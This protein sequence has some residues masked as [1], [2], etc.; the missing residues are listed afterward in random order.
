[1]VPADIRPLWDA[2]QNEVSGIHFYWITY[3]QLFGRSNERIELL[4]ECA[5][6][7]FYIVQDTLLKDIQLSL[8]K[9]A[10]RVKT[11]GNEN[12]T[13]ERLSNEIAALPNGPLTANL[14]IEYRKRCQAITERRHKQ[15][16][17]SDLRTFLQ[18]HGHQMGIEVTGP[19]RQEI[20]GA[21]EALRSFMNIIHV[22]FTG[23]PGA[24][25]NFILGD[26][27]S[28]VSILKRGLRYDELAENHL[29]PFDDIQDFDRIHV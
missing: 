23:S 28:L 12:A 25:E 8:V 21:L 19:S 14:L 7:F 13:L 4:N 6:E 17:H 15:L 22:H 10:D 16:A 18:Q 3:R 1:M 27:D 26:N 29:I 2:L 11:M 20:E 24:D 5:P 9:L